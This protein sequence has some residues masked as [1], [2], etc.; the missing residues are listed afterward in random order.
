[1]LQQLPA[2]RDEIFRDVANWEGLNSKT[3]IRRWASAERA[4]R[5]LKLSKQ[6]DQMEKLMVPRAF[7]IEF[8]P[9]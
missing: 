6:T 2:V 1:L 5:P 9:D 8:Y 7:T 4:K 3:V